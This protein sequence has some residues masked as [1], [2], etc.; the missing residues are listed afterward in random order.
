M[1]QMGQIPLDGGLR[2]EPPEDEEDEEEIPLRRVQQPPAALTGG[3]TQQASPSADAV[4]EDEEEKDVDGAWPP[5]AGQIVLAEFKGQRWP[6][7][8]SKDATCAVSHAERTVD[9]PCLYSLP[10]VAACD[11]MCA[12]RYT[13]HSPTA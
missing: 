6:A 3:A 7:V 8:L 11:C 9:S 10:A 12:V 13:H 4:E 2:H 1:L 5:T